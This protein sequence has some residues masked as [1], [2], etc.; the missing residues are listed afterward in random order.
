MDVA[1]DRFFFF[2]NEAHDAY[3]SLNPD[4]YDT[5][6]DNDDILQTGKC[7]SHSFWQCCCGRMQAHDQS[8]MYNN[9][10]FKISLLVS[11]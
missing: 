7:N 8:Y 11:P 4:I 3:I 9:T 6:E 5:V 10:Y 2:L 1:V